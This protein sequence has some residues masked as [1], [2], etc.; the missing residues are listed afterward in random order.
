MTE[1]T[2]PTRGAA[3]SRTGAIIQARMSSTRL[4]GKVLKDLPYGSGVS[5]LVQ[6]V[7]RTRRATTVDE[8][9]VATSDR[10]EDDAIVAVC[11]AEGFPCFRGS[12]EDVLSRYYHAAREFAFDVVVRVTADCP[13]IDPAIIDLV[14][15]R[16]LE[17]GSDY[18]ANNRLRTFPH[19]LDL[20]VVDAE[21]LGLM[22]ERAVA[23][24][25]REH[26]CPYLERDE[27]RK[28][29]VE[30]PPDWYG[31]DIRVTLD[32]PR[33]YALLCAVFDYLG[34]DFDGRDIVALFQKKPWLRLVNAEDAG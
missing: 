21:A 18:T 26:V 13:C 29:N 34:T 32:T 3:E 19:G 27:F 20:E 5:D 15:K 16:H 7:R 31:P 11:E 22:N 14:V 8:V 25:D 1:T 33:D 24:F 17:G 9:V 28:V 4:P 10:P 6:V 30:A 12:L 23:P 2:G